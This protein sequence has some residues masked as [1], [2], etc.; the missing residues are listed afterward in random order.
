MSRPLTLDMRCAALRRMQRQPHQR[1]RS[2]ARRI[3]FRIRYKNADGSTETLRK[4]SMIN[5]QGV[6]FP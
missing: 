4:S 1:R 6:P 3:A 5:R 2:I